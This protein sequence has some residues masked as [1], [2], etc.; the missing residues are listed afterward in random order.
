MRSGQSLQEQT[1]AA[2]LQALRV[3]VVH[4][5]LTELGGAERVLAEIFALYPDA[6]LFAAVD[7]LSRNQC[8]WLDRRVTTSFVQH[9]PLARRHYRAYLPVMPIAIE[10]WDFSRYDLVISSSHAIAKGVITGPDQVHLSY[11][12]TPMRYAWDLQAAYLEHTRWGWPKQLMARWLLHRL[13]LWDQAATQRVDHLVANSHFV[14]ARIAR[15]YGR[16][17]VVVPPPVAV[18]RFP[19]SSRSEDYYLTVCRLV[20]HKR[21][22][23]I[24]EAFAGMPDTRLIV[25]GDGPERAHIEAKRPANVTMLG[26]QPD[27]VVADHMGRCR[28][29]ILAA[30]EDFGIAPVEAQACGKPVVALNAGGARETLAGLD[31]ANPTAIF[32]DSQDVDALRAAVRQ[33]ERMHRHIRPQDCRANALRYAPDRFRR[34]FADAVQHALMSHRPAPG[35]APAMAG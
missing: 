10:Q 28:G 25:I 3:A 14:A 15:A 16:D 27:P 11:V 19:L 23:L 35:I 12:H 9:L 17:A 30:V 33:M 29:Y 34:D 13:R 1:K 4:D 2:P 21:V 31:S 6:D 26:R 5:W 20:P 18:D 7:F 32:F 24:V 22:D 8:D